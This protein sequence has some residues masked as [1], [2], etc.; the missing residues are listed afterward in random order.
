[1]EQSN[2]ADVAHDGSMVIRTTVFRLFGFRLF[3]ACISLSN[4]DS[5]NSVGLK[6][7]YFNFRS[8]FCDHNSG[9]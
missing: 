8:C 4:Q 6:S 3:F 2:V 1:M 7:L 5:N 9:F